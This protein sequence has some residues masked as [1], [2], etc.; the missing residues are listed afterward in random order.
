[1]LNWLSTIFQKFVSVRLNRCWQ[2]VCQKFFGVGDNDFTEVQLLE[3][4]LQK[5][6]A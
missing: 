6:S 3:I 1:M 5:V 2:S 4:Q